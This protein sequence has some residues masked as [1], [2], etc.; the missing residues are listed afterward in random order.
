MT[1]QLILTSGWLVAF[2]FGCALWWT[3]CRLERKGKEMDAALDKVGERLKSRDA[4]IDELKANATKTIE[5]LHL[6]LDDARGKMNEALQ[7]NAP[8]K[9][10]V[11][12][13][14][15]KLEKVHTRCS[16]LE[17]KNAKLRDQLAKATSFEAPTEHISSSWEAA[18]ALAQKLPLGDVVV[19]KGV[20]YTVAAAVKTLE[21][22][23][24]NE[25]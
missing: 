20:R 22:E 9:A 8:L 4:L 6:N 23:E 24:E 12:R 15:D 11:K 14:K 19:Y 10:Q 25:H 7:A 17:S 1:D 13:L 21:R 5:G 2:A 3:V 16:N 18:R